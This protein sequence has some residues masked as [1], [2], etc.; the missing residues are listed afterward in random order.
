MHPCTLHLHYRGAHTPVV[1]QQYALQHAHTCN[2]IFHSSLVVASP[3]VAQHIAYT[4]IVCGHAL[5][6]PILTSIMVPIRFHFGIQ[7]RNFARGIAQQTYV[8]ILAFHKFSL[9]VA[10]PFHKHRESTTFVMSMFSP[11]IFMCLVLVAHT[12]LIPFNP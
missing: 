7:L 12:N 10:H 6:R 11:L 9:L 8:V 3:W 1:H 2:F 5:A 4:A